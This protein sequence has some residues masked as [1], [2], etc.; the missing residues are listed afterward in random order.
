M[1]TEAKARSLLNVAGAVTASGLTWLG[2]GLLNKA[3]M[4]STTFA[5]G[6]ELVYLPAGFRLLIILIFGFWGAVGIFIANPILFLAHFGSTSLEEIAVNS[7]ISAFAPL[8]A[9]T[10]CARLCGI[11]PSLV[12]LKPVHLPIL[13]LAVS[14]ATPLLFNLQF[15][16]FGRAQ[17]NAVLAQFTAMSLGDFI[18][19]LM[20][21]GF[22]RLLIATYRAV[23]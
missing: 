3:L 2:I 14:L 7:A 16:L 8:L 1:E 10:A 4:A 9:V 22:A 19:C 21:I 17:S 6:I 5:T 13:A 12:R 20:V 11:D 23:T 15:I 18:G